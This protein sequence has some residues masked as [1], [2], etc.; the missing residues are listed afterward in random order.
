[1]V[2]SVLPKF[3]EIESIINE[4]NSLLVDYGFEVH[5]T[6]CLRKF[7]YED[8]TYFL[9]KSSYDD[10]LFYFLFRKEDES[11]ILQYEAEREIKDSIMLDTIEYLFELIVEAYDDLKENKDSIELKDRAILVSALIEE[12]IELSGR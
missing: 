6:E 9:L 3:E 10:K 11:W 8:N 4:F 1:M 5:F 7:E 12:S 2:K